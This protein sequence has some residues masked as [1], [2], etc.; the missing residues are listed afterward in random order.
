[1]ENKQKQEVQKKVSLTEIFDG[2]LSS[3]KPRFFDTDS[4]HELL[5]HRYQFSRYAQKEK[6]IDLVTQELSI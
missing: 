4:L 5:C 3:Q 2:S 6:L 1:M